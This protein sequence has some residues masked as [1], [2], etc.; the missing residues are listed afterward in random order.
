M[1]RSDKT[2][3]RKAIDSSKNAYRIASGGERRT[4]FDNLKKCVTM[5]LKEGV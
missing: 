5:A 2:K 3:L 4:A 1:T